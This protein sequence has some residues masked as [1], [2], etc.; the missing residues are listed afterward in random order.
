[1]KIN[2]TKLLVQDIAEN[3]KTTKAGIILADTVK[4]DSMRGKV[5]EVGEGTPDIKIP[6]SVGDTVLYHPRSGSKFHLDDQEYRL[7]DVNE[8]FLGG[9]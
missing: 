2:N 3:S 8:I 6:Y 5:V 1:M 4:I 9:I 7:V